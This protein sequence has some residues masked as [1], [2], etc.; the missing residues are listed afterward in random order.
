M[1][2]IFGV[3]GFLFLAAL[4]IV[5]CVV[6]AYWNGEGFRSYLSRAVAKAIGVEGRFSSLRFRGF[7]VGS[8]GFSGVGVS[9]SP[10]AELR[11][12]HLEARFPL[13]SLGRGV[14]RIDPL[15]IGHLDLAFRSA[16]SEEKPVPARAGSAEPSPAGEGAPPGLHRVTLDRG[17]IEKADFR[18]PA[19]LLGGGALTG[20]RVAFEADGSSWNGKATGGGLTCASLPTLALQELL[21]RIDS[22]SVVLEQGRL[23]SE[24][25]GLIR[26]A[27]RFRWGEPQ[28]GGLDFSTAGV[29]LAPWLPPAWRNR[30][31]GELEAEGRL[32]GSRG[33]PWK[34]EA[35]LSLSHGKLEDLPWL[36]GLAL[37]GGAQGAL[38]LDQARARLMAGPED[39]A[40]EGIEIESKGRMR[41]EGNL[42]VQRGQL[43]GGLMVGLAAERVAL[44]PGAREK[45]F[46]EERNG[47]LWTPV[48]VTGTVQD[49]QEDLSPRVAALAKEAVKAGVQ[50]AIRSALDFLRHSQGP[51]NP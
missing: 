32:A 20:T 44:L 19:S 26:L 18:W 35:N 28:G 7:A 22:D 16:R 2:K 17:E 38:P 37:S 4:A 41:V 25:S 39:L 40:F 8:G 47:Y 36:V 30:V 50:R 24:G 48:T 49:P 13:S 6:A 31:A 12:E 11:A 45:I 10:I 23:R 46:S 27:G 5:F 42:R 3:L 15:R 43:R 33:E 34:A 51:P 14:W 29:L 9:G 21:F 1:K